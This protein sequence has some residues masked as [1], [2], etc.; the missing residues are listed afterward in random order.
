MAY[1]IQWA[2]SDNESKLFFSKKKIFLV[3]EF[4]EKN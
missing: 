1:V 2:E 3:I 4:L